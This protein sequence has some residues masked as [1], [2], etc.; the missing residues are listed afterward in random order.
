MLL[1]MTGF[2]EGRAESP[3]I[4]VVAELRSINNRHLKISYRSSDGYHGLEPEAERLVRDRVRRG[5]VQLN[6]RVDRRS[7]AGD[8]RINHEVL[9][10][11]QEQL[12]ELGGV[13]VQPTLDKLLTL[14][15]VIS[16][17]DATGADPEADW[18][19]IQKAINAALESLDE[20]RRREGEALAADLLA[21]TAA[22]TTELAGIEVRSP[23]VADAYRERLQ[24][25][26]GQAIE[27]VGVTLEPS[28]LVREVAL[29][30][31]RSDISEEIVRLRS[32]L[33][34]FEATITEAAKSKDGVGRKL[35]FIAQE[36]GREVNTIGSKANDSEISARVVE[37]KAAL[38]RVREQVQNV[39]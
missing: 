26:V 5:T 3:T 19:T 30:V 32:H 28:D 10:A 8:Y 39:E 23:L 24:E 14:P 6:V 15:G 20:M 29:F 34:Q 16:A 37:M 21:Q 25:R 18:P 9:L 36:M 4:A 31:D 22:V 17:P 1:S 11:Y 12:T 38:E 33:V 27:K 7:R 13:H 35:E 2:G